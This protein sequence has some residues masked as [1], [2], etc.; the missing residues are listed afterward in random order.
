[1]KLPRNLGV[2]VCSHVFENNRPLLYVVCDEDNYYHFM[3]GG[4]DHLDE[5][6]AHYV[7]L[8]HVIAKDSSLEGLLPK[9]GLSCE[10]ERKDESSEW[11]ISKISDRD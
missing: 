11:T 1:M 4:H 9:L 2:I 8:G 10:A 5:N 7:G 6:D 3:C